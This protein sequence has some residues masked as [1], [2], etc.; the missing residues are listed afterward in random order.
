MQ[1]NDFFEAVKQ[2]NDI[3]NCMQ[4]LRKLEDFIKTL[5]EE[6]HHKLEEFINQPIFDFDVHSAAD[7]MKYFKEV[8]K[9]YDVLKENEIIFKEEFD[10]FMIK[11]TSLAADRL[12]KKIKAYCIENQLSEFPLNELEWKTMMIYVK[13]LQK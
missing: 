1:G 13:N 9:D 3:V 7:W 4:V 8:E 10:K 2:S 6:E 5:T 11:E 12:L